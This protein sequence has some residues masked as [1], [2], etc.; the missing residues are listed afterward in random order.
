MTTAEYVQNGNFIDFTAAAEVAYM[1]VVPLES[2]VG[3]AK[4]PLKAGETGTLSVT[5]VYKLPAKSGIEIKQG[6]LVYWN[7]T[8]GVIDTK[9]ATTVPA[10]WA[11][12]AK[13]T[14]GTSIEVKIG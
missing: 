8:D 10:G 1:E 11:I 2:C 9:S 12:A 4:T 14:T 13:T 5:G 3:V 7:N 6:D